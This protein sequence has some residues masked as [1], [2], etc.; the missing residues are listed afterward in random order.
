LVCHA[1]GDVLDKRLLAPDLYKYLVALASVLEDVGDADGGRQV[2]HI[3]KFISGS[4]SEL[5]GEARLL[6]PT[7]LQRSGAR[8]A[9]LDRARLSEAIAGIEQEFRRIG[10][11]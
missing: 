6:L 8:L 5:Y 3:S 1:I 2:L 10:G 11:G 9:D 7:I 4:T